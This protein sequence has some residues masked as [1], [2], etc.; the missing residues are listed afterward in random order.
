MLKNFLF[1]LNKPNGL[2]G[3]LNKNIYVHIMLITQ[4][5]NIEI[6]IHKHSYKCIFVYIFISLTINIFY[7]FK[8]SQI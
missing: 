4:R 5:E 1:L 2:L 6:F 3:Y 7:N 8:C